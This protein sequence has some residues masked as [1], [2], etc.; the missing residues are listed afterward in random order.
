[1]QCIPL[2]IDER[3]N[4]HTQVVLYKV[5]CIA[6]PPV[7]YYN[8]LMVYKRVCAKNLY[9]PYMRHCKVFGY[10]GMYGVFYYTLSMH[11]VYIKSTLFGY[12]SVNKGFFVVFLVYAELSVKELQRFSLKIHKNGY[13]LVLCFFVKFRGYRFRL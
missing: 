11:K 5:L 10:W 1:M 9:R 13:F 4:I 8:I 6:V 2:C 12:L 7:Y 3:A